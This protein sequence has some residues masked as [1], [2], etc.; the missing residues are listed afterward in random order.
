MGQYEID[1]SIRIS[2]KGQDCSRGTVVGP[3][4]RGPEYTA[5][6]RADCKKLTCPLCGP[7]KA[8]AYRKA[9]GAAA[10][11]NRLTR[12]MTL[13]LDPSK[14]D[15][16]DS[17]AYLRKCFNKFRVYL[18]RKFGQAVSFIAIVEEQ[19][20]GRAHMHCLVGIFIDQRWI[21]DT[22]QAV[23]GGRIVDI[24]LIDVHRIHAYVAKYLT[25]EFLL[26]VPAGKKRISTSRDIRLFQKH[27][28]K[29]WSWRRDHIQDCYYM[30][31]GLG[32][33]RCV[34]RD[35]V[36]VRSFL[37]WL[38]SDLTSVKRDQTGYPDSHKLP[39]DMLSPQESFPMEFFA[40]GWGQ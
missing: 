39:P 23:G 12:M 37:V 25:K 29:G 22:W 30:A 1:N 34:D 17:V 21:S 15:V 8:V 38:P 27:S 10:E 28:A 14:I 36:G 24:R 6:I 3:S 40:S 33:V 5:H 11:A 2:G 16:A 9:I 31:P 32:V 26:S 20:N 18:H 35:S 7:K 13:T 19:K 4:S